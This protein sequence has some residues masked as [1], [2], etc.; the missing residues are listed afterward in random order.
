M[1]SKSVKRFTYG[2]VGGTNVTDD[3]QTDDDTEEC[4]GI[5]GTKKARNVEKSR[6]TNQHRRKLTR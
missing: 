1:A 5:G 4:V 2:E 6:R 3:R